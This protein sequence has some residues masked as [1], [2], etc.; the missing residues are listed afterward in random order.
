MQEE[1]CRD[2]HSYSLLVNNQKNML[3]ALK[4]MLI[5]QVGP[6]IWLE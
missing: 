1:K 5:T 3:I 4:E 6:R 2:S